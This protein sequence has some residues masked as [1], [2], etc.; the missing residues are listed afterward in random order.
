VLL[1][2]LPREGN[3]PKMKVRLHAVDERRG[4]S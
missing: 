1:I 2:V 3:F 4:A